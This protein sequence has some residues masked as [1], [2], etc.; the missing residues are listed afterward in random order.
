MRRGWW[1]LVYNI[2]LFENKTCSNASHM[3]SVNRICFNASHLNSLKTGP[4]SMHWIRILWR[5]DLIQCIASEFFE[6]RAFSLYCIH[7]LWRQDLIQCILSEFFEDRSYFNAS[8]QNSM[9]IGPA[10]LHLI[11]ILWGQDLLQYN[12]YDF[13]TRFHQVTVVAKYPHLNSLCALYLPEPS[14]V[15]VLT[16]LRHYC[17]NNIKWPV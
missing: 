1:I 13:C 3:N 5:Q 12:A 11:C 6:D 14:Y 15:F 2:E 9:N 8:H 10:S 4:N 16:H 17:T 7:I